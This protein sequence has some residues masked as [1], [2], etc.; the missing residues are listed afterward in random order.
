MGQILQSCLIERGDAP[1]PELDPI[2]EQI[3]DYLHNHSQYPPTALL[4]IYAQSKQCSKELKNIIE[5]GLL[6]LKADEK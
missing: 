2:I 6:E 1:N 3:D 5:S 4:K